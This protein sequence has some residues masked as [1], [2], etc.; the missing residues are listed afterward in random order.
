MNP[1]KFFAELKRR[2]VYKVA[3]AYGIV[4]WL[5][6]QVATQVFPF[7]EVPAWGVRLVILAIVFGFPFALIFAWAFEITP[8]GLMRTEEVESDKSIRRSTGRKLD[9]LIIA[10]LL[11][12][13][14]MLVFQRSRSVKQTP[15]SSIPEKSIAVLPFENLSEEKA[16]AYF[17]DAMQDEILSRLGKI[18]DLRVISRTST[19][20]YRGSPANVLEIAKQLGVS[21]LLE[22]SVQR[23]ADQV[24]IHV[25]LIDART[26]ASMWGESYNRKFGDILNL[27]S[28]VAQNVAETLNARLTGTEKERLT[29]KLTVSEAAYDAYLRGRYLLN[30]RTIES[31]QEARTLFEQAVAQDNRFAVGHAAIADSYILLAEYG[32]IS[33]QEASALAWPEVT[34]ALAC[35]DGFAAPY[36]SRAM[37]LTD[38][39][40]NWPVAEPD[41]KKALELNPNSALA[42]HWYAFHLAETGRV[43]EALREIDAARQLDPFSAIVRAAKAKILYMARRYDE[44]I[45]LAREAIE[46]EA[47]S[48]PAFSVLARAYAAHQQY[49]QAMEAAK[50]YIELEPGEWGKLELAYVAAA[51]GNRAEAERVAGEVSPETTRSSP[52]DNAAV[53]AALHDKAGALRWLGSAIRQHAMEAVWMR[54]DPRFSDLRD[55][56]GFRELLTRLGPKREL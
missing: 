37:L 2:N 14:G 11:V 19:Q 52:Y 49:P 53:C 28:E 56:P 38:F 34:A 32:A 51:A 31:I 9:F 4:A 24:R 8:E 17:A 45:A 27:E 33:S 40:W 21:H 12:V 7:F 1:R 25:Q 48:A 15:P 44:A 50:K 20:R 18:G 47:N 54:V 55:E 10:V 16:N 5:L 36:I 42:H 35:N 30:K 39:E 3:V 43:D 41:F 13:I 22:G 23:A 46:L 29:A 6:I 26:E